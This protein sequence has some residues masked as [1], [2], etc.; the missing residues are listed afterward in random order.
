MPAP[1]AAAAA[2]GTKTAGAGASQTA[3]GTAPTA[4]S[5]NMDGISASGGTPKPTQPSA[6]PPSTKPSPPSENQNKQIES[7]KRTQ[8]LRRLRGSGKKE[9]KKP[10]KPF[11]IIMFTFALTIDLL[12]MIGLNYY[13]LYIPNILGACVILPW[14]W[15]QKKPGDVSPVTRMV[16][17][18]II[19]WIPI[20][21]SIAPGWTGLVI[22]TWWKRR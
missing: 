15:L 16:A 13:L 4:G 8:L 1:V 12:E 2:A 5:G 7:A 22:L 14:V 18:F 11:P 21:G 10:P 19:E 9:E 17:T 3:A 6:P 20:I